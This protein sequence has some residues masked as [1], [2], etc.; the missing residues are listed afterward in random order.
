[1]ADNVKGINIQIGGDTQPLNKAL[2][3]ATQA[4]SKLQQSIA[5]VNKD[6]KLDPTNIDLI[7]KKVNLVREQ[8]EN[9]AQQAD[10]LSEALS[11]AK[12]Q[13]QAGEI[14][15][16]QLEEIQIAFDR[17]VDK[18]EEY[19]QEMENLTDLR[20]SLE[21]AHAPLNDIY[22]RIEELQ[23]LISEGEM[24]LDKER[25]GFEEY[26]ATTKKVEEYRAEIERLQKSEKEVE[27]TVEKTKKNIIQLNE[28]RQEQKTILE[29]VREEQAKNNQELE[30]GNPILQTMSDSY[31]KMMSTFDNMNMQE[32]ITKTVSLIKSFVQEYTKLLDQFDKADIIKSTFAQ[33][34]DEVEKSTQA[35]Q[36]NSKEIRDNTG[37]LK[38]YAQRMVEINKS[39][40]AGNKAGKDTTK[41][42]NQLN[43]YVR[44]SNDLYGENIVQIDSQ[45]GA[46]KNTNKELTDM[47]SNF[48][49]EK[50][51]I[52]VQER[53][54]ELYQQLAAAQADIEATE[55]A[56]AEGRATRGTSYYQT[57]NDS[58]ALYQQ[59]T[60]EISVQE[61]KLED[62]GVTAEASLGEITKYQAMAYVSLLENGEEIT[63]E[64]KKQ[65]EEFKKNHKDTYDFIVKTVKEENKQYQELYKNRV[66]YATKS[67]H[68]ITLSFDQSLKDR[69]DILKKNQSIIN[70]YEKNFSKAVEYVSKIQDEE[71]RKRW[72][73]Y[74]KT[75]DKFSEENAVI[76]AQM[77]DDIETSGGEG[78]KALVDAWN[79]GIQ[80]LPDDFK[81]A[82]DKIE[83]MTEKTIK[84][85]KEKLSFTVD[86]K[87]NVTG[88]RGYMKVQAF[89]QGGIVTKPT[90]SLM[91]EAGPEAIIPLDRMGDILSNAFERNDIRPN[92]NN[93]MNVYVQDMTYGQREA[94]FNEFNRWLTRGY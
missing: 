54:Y 33:T 89:A 84:M 61:K 63:E 65:L 29:E 36:K 83:S 41:L 82:L 46:L 88:G 15:R 16:Q 2:K 85:V 23:E 9:T 28:K 4:S 59:I 37:T 38:I 56:I 67:D 48:E 32:M 27:K 30:K 21:E 77:V 71:D 8:F 76:L 14:T 74:L 62:L 43:G 49:K 57:L 86:A 90:Y 70:D 26:E 1:M 22:T 87:G 80:D 40:I 45:T 55:Q 25:L 78:A 18:A 20:N 81:E 50:E 34:K 75:L 10:M 64:N 44:M 79:E 72:A 42:Q 39:I 3:E 93:S 47:I 17:T 5:L 51:G 52:A 13:F 12:M 92:Q 24:K 91:G 66:T 68:E 6:L 69:I 58:K 73:E 19:K 31:S 60:E 35:F 94:L 11:S 7:N 53:L